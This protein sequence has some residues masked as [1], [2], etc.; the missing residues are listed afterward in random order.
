VA[1]IDGVD[2]CVEVRN[3]QIQWI[4]Y[5]WKLLTSLYKTSVMI[6]KLAL[7]LS[8]LAS[9]GLLLTIN[10]CKEKDLCD[11][12]PVFDIDLFVNQVEQ[13][14]NDDSNPVSGYEFVVSQGGNVYHKNG[15]GFAVYASDN[16]GPMPMD[17]NTRINVAS[18]SKFIGTI[19]LMQV[20]EKHNINSWA[21]IKNYLPPTWQNVMHETHYKAN[22]GTAITFEDLLTMKTG[23][24]FGDPSNYSP[25]P[26]PTTA[27]MYR[28]IGQPAD[29]DRENDYQ[30]GNFTMIRVL[31]AELE[32]GLD[33]TA[34]D[35][36]Y[37]TAE[38]YFDYIKRNIFDKLDLTPPM[39][40]PAVDN[41]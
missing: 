9:I 18:V 30:N 22:F 32:Y 4:G 10:S 14:L 17:E 15:G 25:G 20:L 24:Q 19:A 6:K 16:G 37:Q 1:L 29:S 21:Y 38:A 40:I 41:F 5:D 27:E 8:L 3:I 2:D 34:N 13:A 28:A 39:M 26:I 36:N 31:I 11:P 7:R 35:Y 12:T 33:E 23:I